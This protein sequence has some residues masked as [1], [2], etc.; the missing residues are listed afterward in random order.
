MALDVFGVPLMSDSNERSFS[1]GRDMITYRRTRLVNDI[2]EAC[3]CLR[4][5]LLPPRGR[6]EDLF[7]DEDII[8]DDMDTSQDSDA[9]GEPFTNTLPN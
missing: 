9:S 8:I 7:D 6:K 2:I 5:W 4:S 3:Q 1:S